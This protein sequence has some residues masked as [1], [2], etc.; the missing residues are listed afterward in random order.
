MN[1]N[2]AARF[3]GATLRTV[4]G[5]LLLLGGV[6]AVLLSQHLYLF[7]DFGIPLRYE[8][9]G[10][11]NAMY[12]KSVLEEGWPLAWNRHLAAPFGAAHFDFPGAEAANIALIHLL[13]LFAGDWASVANAHLVLGY[14]LVAIA[15]YW[16]GGRLGMA[17]PWRLLGALLFTFLPVHGMRPNH[18][19]LA[20]YFAVP[21]SVW[22]AW[23]VWSAH[24]APH[25]AGERKAT[26]ACALIVGTSGVYYA[27][28]CCYL[29][30][31]AMLAG[32]AQRPWRPA[33]LRGS[34]IIALV[35]GAVTLQILP[36]MVYKAVHGPNPEVA[37]RTISESE[38]FA[39][40]VTQLVL[41]RRDHRLGAAAALNDR[42]YLGLGA[43][44][45]SLT[46]TATASLGAIGTL[47]FLFLL[48]HV[49]R[50]LH[51]WVQSAPLLDGLAAFNATLL[52]L[53]T[54]GGFGTLFA[55]LVS[56]LVRAYNRVSVVIAFVAICAVML[57]LDRY[58][59][60]IAAQRSPAG[61]PLPLHR[62]ALAW[63]CALL[64]LAAGIFD[65]TSRRDLQH[66]DLS[67]TSDRDFVRDLEAALPARAMVYQMPFQS[68]P[69]APRQFNLSPYGPARGY[70]HSKDL[71]WS[72]G[73]MR[74]REGHRWLETVSRLPLARQLEVAAQS[75]FE[76]VMVDRR[77]LRDRG[78]ALEGQL[79]NHL[80][81]PMASSADGMLV[82]YRMPRKGDRPV[83]FAELAPPF[84]RWTASIPEVPAEIAKLSGFSG[85]EA[86]GRWTQ[87]PVAR[88]ELG[89]PL[90]TE[91][92]LEIRT[93]FA[94][95]PNV[96][97]P[98]AV[99]VGNVERSFTVG[100]APTN[101][102]LPFRLQRPESVIEIRIPHPVSPRQLGLGEDRRELG[103]GIESLAIRR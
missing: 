66:V 11:F 101:V 60:R 63:I 17:L 49:L 16:V 84:E 103:V 2:F 38:A 65:Q 50:R 92:V 28:F 98:I 64:L 102:E 9:D 14:F 91:F 68:F 5:P 83:P 23:T 44:L 93:R 76:A 89:R 74:G 48:W 41:P 24:Q 71:R 22:L 12:V 53:G 18:L 45:D 69:E 61:L 81:A 72:F 73:H 27:F 6:A 70:L 46:E 80:G 55:L 3:Q 31:V 86:W 19:L 35:A 100:A 99:S 51:G 85:A 15:A 4:S 57:V 88:I 40:K 29:A 25:W 32:A 75:G 90:P 77:G 37:T 67:F 54:V 1:K 20:S 7:R 33:L 39:L 62:A 8:G 42:Y 36:T 30:V 13:G 95:R 79:A 34:F 97:V 87:G 96:D 56:P 21:L 59:A 58:F 26:V 82:A 94:M 10:L 78:K 52:L 47:G 43:H